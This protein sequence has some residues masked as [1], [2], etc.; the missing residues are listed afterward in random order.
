MPGF[1]APALFLFA[2]VS[3]YDVSGRAVLPHLHVAFLALFTLF[4]ARLWLHC[5]LRRSPIQV[6]LAGLA[7]AAAVGTILLYY[8][9]VLIGLES[10]GRVISW[11]LIATYWTQAVPFAEALGISL[12]L[13]VGILVL[14]YAAILGAVWWYLAKLD[15][16]PLVSASL[17]TR[18][19]RLLMVAGVIICVAQW[20]EFTANPPVAQFE[21]VSLT[22]FASAN[23]HDLQGHAIDQLR[24]E[25]LDRAE[26]AARAEY[27]PGASAQRRNVILIVVDALRPDHLHFNGYERETTPNLDRLAQA[28]RIRQIENVHA[29]CSASSC[30]L[31]AIAASRFVHQFSHRPFTLH[32]V[33]KQHGY[34]TSM[35]LSGDHANFYGL[36]QIYGELDEY[37]DS[38][39]LKNRYLNDDQVVVDRIAAQPQWDGVPVAMQIHLMSTHRLGKRHAES[40][41][42][43]PSASYSIKGGD[44]DTNIQ[45]VVNYYDN[46]VLH[47]DAVIAEILQMLQAKGYLSDALVVITADHGES[48]GE[49]GVFSHA[50]APTEEQL[51]IPLLLIAYG[52]DP[53]QSLH[54][55]SSAS[56]LDIGPTILAELGMPVPSTWVGVPLQHP[57]VPDYTYFQQ[58]HIAGLFD[59]RDGASTWKYLV[60]GRTGREQAFNLG[61]DKSATKDL[62]ASIPTG[63]KHH[64][65]QHY[66]QVLTGGTGVFD[67]A[68]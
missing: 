24:A 1:P 8:A 54:Q 39:M 5:L 7:V 17:P 29:P 57:A 20:Y 25:K 62:I 30:G 58:G 37:F 28:G 4:T 63:L 49:N 51:R 32:Q 19:F 3:L 53:Q 44:E 47:T 12:A 15:W 13:I 66:L 43:L 40:M 59:H 18:T 48:L 52:Y 21:P 26:N 2:Y 45:R 6:V 60:D 65:R 9:L 55:K 38:S 61:T 33:F 41:R 14:T 27:R 36:R 10:W 11:E 50:N 56:Q 23:A 64:W 68:D 67:H 46:G 16:V 34:R 42:W 31:Y 22:F 35:I